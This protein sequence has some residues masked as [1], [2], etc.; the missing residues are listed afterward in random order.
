[1]KFNVVSIVIEVKDDEPSFKT[2]INK[3]LL[4]EIGFTER[5]IMIID[6]ISRFVHVIWIFL[7]RFVQ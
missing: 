5:S 2:N 6:G 7:V 1:M 4:S 3:N